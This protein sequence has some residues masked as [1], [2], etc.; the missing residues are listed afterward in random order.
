MVAVFGQP[1]SL[2]GATS[3]CVCKFF[4][5]HGRGKFSSRKTPK[6]AI[7]RDFPGLRAFSANVARD[8]NEEQEIPHPM[9]KSAARFGAPKSSYGHFSHPAGHG[10]G[11]ASLKCWWHV[12]LIPPRHR[13]LQLRVGAP[14]FL[15]S[16]LQVLCGVPDVV[17]ITKVGRLIKP[18]DKTCA[19]RSDS[20]FKVTGDGEAQMWCND[21]SGPGVRKSFADSCNRLGGIKVL[22][23]QPA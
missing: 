4:R 23:S 1:F 10:R 11:K 9:V 7:N 3:W 19:D 14:V 5:G 22:R 15:T 18:R 20:F 12:L 16:A 6:M 8:K 2:R 13:A 17:V 21:Y